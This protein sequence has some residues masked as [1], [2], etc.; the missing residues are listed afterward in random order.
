MFLGLFLIKKNRFV[1]NRVVLKN[2]RNL[3]RISKN[4]HTTVGAG[5]GGEGGGGG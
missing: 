3:S 2:T 4:S 5:V 1:S